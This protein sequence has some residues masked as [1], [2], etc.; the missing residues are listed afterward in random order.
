MDDSTPSGELHNLPDVESFVRQYMSDTLKGMELDP[1][2]NITDQFPGLQRGRD[3]TPAKGR[4][5]KRSASVGVERDDKPKCYPPRPVIFPLEGSGD[6]F[7]PDL[8]KDL[9][10]SFVDFR[11]KFEA[12]NIGHRATLAK[13]QEV[14]CCYVTLKH[15]QQGTA[16]PSN[17]RSL[18]PLEY[19][20]ES[21]DNLRYKIAGYL[22]QTSQEFNRD[23]DLYGY[24]TDVFTTKV[25]KDFN[26]NELLTLN[27]TGARP[28]GPVQTTKI[29][30]RT[31][32]P[33]ANPYVSDLK[34]SMQ[35]S[36]QSVDYKSEDIRGTFKDLSHCSSSSGLLTRP[37]AT[38]T[39]G[40]LDSMDNQSSALDARINVSISRIIRLAL[41]GEKRRVALSVFSVNS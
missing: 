22:G 21:L 16:L 24:T 37:S 33:P 29:K 7:S 17:L 32:N 39:L 8:T 30:C 11:N 19:N 2:S 23:S 13:I 40:Q 31:F 12:D 27:S 36:P 18:I 5:I 4:G 3:E 14:F 9:M 38:I 41:P 1:S 35:P 20:R 28:K 15:K 26:R 6:N 34:H 10:Y 25:A